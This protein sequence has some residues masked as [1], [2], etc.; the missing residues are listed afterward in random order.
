M[1][2]DLLRRSLALPTLAVGDTIRGALRP[3]QADARV[4]DGRMM[5]HEHSEARQRSDA[6]FHEPHGGDDS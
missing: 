3:P 5:T 2:A 4:L 1:A 6:V